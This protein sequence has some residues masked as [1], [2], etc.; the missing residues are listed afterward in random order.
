VLVVGWA[1]W[2]RQELRITGAVS[3][4]PLLPA[5]VPP[6]GWWL[7]TSRAGSW[8]P[9]SGRSWV[10]F[11]A[12]AP[13]QPSYRAACVSSTPASAIV[14]FLWKKNGYY[15]RSAPSDLPSGDVKQH[16]SYVRFEVSLSLAVMLLVRSAVWLAPVRSRGCRTGRLVGLSPPDVRSRVW[17]SY[18]APSLL[19]APRD[20]RVGAPHT[21]VNACW[22][23]V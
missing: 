19:W 10:T 4:W 18:M 15:M 12:H 14:S 8:T 20:F 7:A 6:H 9:F 23:S 3:L 1:T 5:V 21:V 22:W 17:M 13:S 16:G 2:S 11:M